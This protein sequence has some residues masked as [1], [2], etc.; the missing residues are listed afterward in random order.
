MNTV[1]LYKI[2]VYESYRRDEHGNHYSFDPWSGNTMY[3]K[4]YDDGGKDYIL[5]DGYTIGHNIAN[6]TMIFDK[7]NMGY[8]IGISNN[9]RPFLPYTA[10]KALILKEYKGEN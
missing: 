4:G 8:D 2:T 1:K 3:Y 10:D 5:P 6:Q 9:G 7:N